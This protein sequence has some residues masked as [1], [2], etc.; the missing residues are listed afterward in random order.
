MDRPSVYRA[1]LLLALT[2]ALT[3]SGCAK[4]ESRRG[5]PITRKGVIKSVNL[6]K[7]YAKVEVHDRTGD[8][9]EMDG[10]FTDETV[11][12]IDGRP[13]KFED[14]RPGDPVEVTVK[15]KGKGLDLDIIALRVDITR[16]AT[17]SSAPAP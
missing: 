9:L 2:A 12:T 4:K 16:A 6:E 13:A 8:K 1:G 11:V 17:T 7:K 14:V 15:L 5:K 10:S 3:L